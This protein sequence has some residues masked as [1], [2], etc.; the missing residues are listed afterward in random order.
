MCASTGVIGQAMILD[1][2]AKAASPLLAR[3]L[4]TD[5]SDACARAI[6][7]TDTSQKG[8]CR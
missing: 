6:M 8:V 3:S 7:T 2:F 4:S 5:G 1:P